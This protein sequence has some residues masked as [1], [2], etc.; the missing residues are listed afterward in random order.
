MRIKIITLVIFVALLAFA[1]TYRFENIGS[2]GEVT[3][4]TIFYKDK[5][6]RF[7]AKLEIMEME[8]ENKELGISLDSNDLN[9]GTVPPESKVTKTLD[10]NNTE[11]VPLKVNIRTI[12]DISSHIWMERNNFVIN[13]GE[14]VKTGI[15]AYGK[16][17]G[18]FEGEVILSMRQ[19]RSA[20]L[21][22][23]TQWL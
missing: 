16:E 9:F 10:I 15:M 6:I 13:P 22:G 20:L 14:S 17:P 19:P 21:G 11:N 23:I 8:I 4:M 18:Y 2:G 3:G 1:A 7:Q 12:G 5:E